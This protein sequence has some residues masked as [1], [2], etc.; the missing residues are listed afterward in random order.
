MTEA[1]RSLRMTGAGPAP[2]DQGI[3]LCSRLPPHPLG[4]RPQFNWDPRGPICFNC[5]EIEVGIQSR[6]EWLEMVAEHE[7]DLRKID[8]TD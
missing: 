6:K 8:G 7:R 3:R 5:W 4:D 2:V 1:D